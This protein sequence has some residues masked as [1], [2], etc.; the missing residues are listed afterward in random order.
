MYL[1][2]TLDKRNSRMILERADA[3]RLDSR[4]RTTFECVYG[5]LALLQPGRYRHP[6]PPIS[7]RRDQI[8]AG[9]RCSGNSAEIT[10]GSR[11]AQRHGCRVR[12]GCCW[13]H[14]HTP[15]SI[16]L[17]IPVPVALLRP[18]LAVDDQPTIRHGFCS[19]TRVV[20]CNGVA[21]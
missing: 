11:A 8:P 12:M 2:R 9:A 15:R 18:R 16:F 14:R 20:P 3:P 21:P 19:S 10:G 1:W 6:S 7:R 5:Q 13:H 4:R 17:R